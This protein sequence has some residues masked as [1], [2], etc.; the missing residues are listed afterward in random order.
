MDE[1]TI[2]DKCNRDFDILI[3]RDLGQSSFGWLPDPR[4]ISTT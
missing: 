2:L 3:D 4:Y 1:E